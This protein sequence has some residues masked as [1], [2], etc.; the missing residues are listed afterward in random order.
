M[1]YQLFN[2][3]CLEILQ[4]IDYRV[5]H[6]ICDPPYGVTACDWDSVIDYNKLWGLLKQIRNKGANI[7]LFSKQPFSSLLVCSN[8]DEYRYE[9]IWKKQQATN[10]MCAKKRIMPIHEN[11]EIFYDSFKTYNPQFSYGHS[12]YSGFK[13]SE[14][15]I[16]EVYGD[17]KSVHNECTDGKRYPISVI[18]YNNVRRNCVH[19]TQKPIDMMEYLVRT[20]SNENDTILD[21]SMGSG[22]TGVACVRCNRNFIGIEKEEKYFHIA[23]ERIKEASL[24]IDAFV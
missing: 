6:I 21:F 24:N 22:S 15:N 9:V 20:Y 17:I 23:E 18:E 4:N 7:V 5:D 8:L 2:G 3:D 19:P 10:P 13:S 16:G 12:N 14:A 1:S 11:I